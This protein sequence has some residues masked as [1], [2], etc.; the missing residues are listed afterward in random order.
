MSNSQEQTINDM[1]SNMMSKT[2]R[3]GVRGSYT[4]KTQSLSLH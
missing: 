4:S 3:E 2:P 1:L